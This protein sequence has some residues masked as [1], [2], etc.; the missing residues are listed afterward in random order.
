MVFVVDSTDKERLSIAKEELEKVLEHDVCKDHYN[1]LYSLFLI[2]YFSHLKILY[3][4]CW[5]TKMI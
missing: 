1:I 2:R 3:Y 5:Q 4:W